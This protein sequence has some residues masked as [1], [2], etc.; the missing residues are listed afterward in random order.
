MSDMRVASPPATAGA[1]GRP[2]SRDA[3]T[4]APT[5]V[6]FGPDEQTLDVYVSHDGELDFA[7]TTPPFA[8]REVIVRAALAGARHWFATDFSKI[9][10][11]T[12]GRL[13]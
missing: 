3:R 9:Y 7:P 12:D 13:H 5:S 11:A 6:G 2:A 4:T 8:H 10:T 1:S